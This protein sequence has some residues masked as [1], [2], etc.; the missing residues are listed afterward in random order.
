MPTPRD[1]ARYK[2]FLGLNNA[3]DF[4]K[5]ADEMKRRGDF[6]TP[7]NDLA[8]IAAAKRAGAPA[9]AFLSTSEVAEGAAAAAAMKAGDGGVLTLTKEQEAAQTA[10]AAAEM[11]APAAGGPSV[12]LAAKQDILE[13]ALFSG[14]WAFA[15]VRWTFYM[16]ALIHV[17]WIDGCCMWAMRWVGHPGGRPLQRQVL[18]IVT[19]LYGRLRALGGCTCINAVCTLSRCIGH[20][21]GCA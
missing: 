5:A 20:Y 17:C 2:N 18:L 16:S 9:D 19:A 6:T 11:K 12:S 4:M 1:V 13:E 15:H 14:R 7:G 21:H 10:A 8:A 3:N